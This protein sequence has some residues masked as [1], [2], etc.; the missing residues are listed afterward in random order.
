MIGCGSPIQ[1]SPL[2]LNYSFLLNQT[3]LSFGS[4]PCAFFSSGAPS[5][6]LLHHIVQTC[7]AVLTVVLPEESLIIAKALCTS[8]R[9]IPRL[10]VNF[11]EKILLA[12]SYC[13]VSQPALESPNSFT[14]WPFLMIKPYVLLLNFFSYLCLPPSSQSIS[15]KTLRFQTS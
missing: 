7:E 6:W 1:R 9:V 11:L 14:L 10:Q 12:W 3:T 5:I 8:V 15:S 2:Q 13:L 4:C